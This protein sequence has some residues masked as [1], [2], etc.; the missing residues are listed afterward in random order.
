MRRAVGMTALAAVAVAAAVTVGGSMASADDAESHSSLVEDYT[1][2]GRD[3]ILAEHGLTLRS[4]D[5]NIMFVPCT[6][7]GDLIKIESYDFA[8][9]VCF[10]LRGEHGFLTLEIARTTYVYSENQ[11]LEASLLIEGEAAPRTKQV[12]E[13]YWTPVGEA[14][15]LPSATLLEI[16]A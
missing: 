14:E 8:D 1:Y 2:P 6:T 9:F 7:D 4:G 15:S 13:N 11:P 12:P 10:Q 5:G 3:A 16:R